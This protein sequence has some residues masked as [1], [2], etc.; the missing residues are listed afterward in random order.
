MVY[1]LQYHLL[2]WVNYTFSFVTTKLWSTCLCAVN[3]WHR[4]VVRGITA[5]TAGRQ[6]VLRNT[7]VPKSWQ[8]SIYSLTYN[9]YFWQCWVFVAACRLSQ[10]AASGGSHCSGFPLRSVGSGARGL[11]Q[12]WHLGLVALQRVGSSQTKDQ[13]M[14]PALEGGF[15]TTALPGKS[16]Q[17]IFKGNVREGHPRVCDQLMGNALI[18]WQWGNRAVCHRVSVPL[19]PSHGKL[20]PEVGDMWLARPHS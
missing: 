6:L 8:Q 20:C 18:C 11:Q 1:F 9:I 12:W 19:T 2:I 3:Y 7:D 4:F 17:N 13:L 10:A 14:S 5:F 15:L 16:Q